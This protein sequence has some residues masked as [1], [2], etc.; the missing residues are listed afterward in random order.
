MIENIAI[1]FGIPLAYIAIGVAALGAIAF[2]IVQM[3]QDLKK[4]VVTFISLGIL[5][6]VFLLCFL[7]AT[8]ASYSVGD[9]HVSAGQMRFVEAGI[10]M[11]YVLLATS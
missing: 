6:L 11:F 4:S 10:I 8:N 7:M 3:A 1:S 5:A 9:I 2:P